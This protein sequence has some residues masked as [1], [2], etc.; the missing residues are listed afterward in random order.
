[1]QLSSGTRRVYT[2]FSMS[3]PL[4]PSLVYENSGGSG[5]NGVNGNRKRQYYRRMQIKN[6]DK[7]QSKTL[8]LASSSIVK[9]VLDCRLPVV[10]IHRPD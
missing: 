4:H 10:S 3:R 9:S 8:F 2:M 1:M 7:R 6:D 5:E